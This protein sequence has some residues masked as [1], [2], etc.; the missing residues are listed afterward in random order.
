M[1]HGKLPVCSSSK[2]LG[3]KEA[4]VK[5]GGDTARG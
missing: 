4:S 1:E 2:G 3:R 5:I